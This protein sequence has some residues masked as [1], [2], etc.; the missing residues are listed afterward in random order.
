MTYLIFFSL[1]LALSLIYSM[2][3]YATYMKGMEPYGADRTREFFWLII[4]M[5]SFEAILF[6]I[7]FTIEIIGVLGEDFYYL[8]SREK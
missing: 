5:V 8:E 3:S 6:P 1:Y 4:W 2:H 7:F